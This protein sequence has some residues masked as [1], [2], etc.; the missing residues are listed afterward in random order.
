MGLH[1]ANLDDNTRQCMLVESQL[2]NH[3]ISP[4]LTEA[5]QARWQEILE[6]AMRLHNDDWLAGQLLSQ[7]LV[8]SEELYTRSGVTRQRRVNQAQAAQQLAEGEFNRYY[9]RGLCL[10]SKSSGVSELI[11]Y[12]GEQVSQPRPESEAKVGTRVGVD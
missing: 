11:V 4:R 1:Y 12:R 9:L 5:G 6:E 3:Y 7:G 8:R 10:R 2:G